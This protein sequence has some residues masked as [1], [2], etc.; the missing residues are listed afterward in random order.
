MS[1]DTTTPVNEAE[2]SAAQDA[3]QEAPNEAPEVNAPVSPE[4][5]ALL[6]KIEEYK[7][8]WQRERADFMNYKRRAEREQS[9]ARGRGAQDAVMKMLPV[10]DD[11]ERVMQVVPAELSGN[12]WFEGIELLFS[13]LDKV[14]ADVQVEKIDPT[15][16][17]F[18]PNMHEAVGVDEPTDEVPSGHVTVTLRKGYV[19]GSR[20]LRPAVVRVAQ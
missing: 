10:M 19:S 20:I 2:N 15:G 12:P 5:T 11:F 7:E 1:Q 3:A 16:Q 9:E 17:P 13:K 14:L 6:A 8:A 18:D 4:V